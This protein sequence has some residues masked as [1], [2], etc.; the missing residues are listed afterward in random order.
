MEKITYVEEPARSIPVMANVDVVVVGGGPAGLSAAVTSARLGMDTLLVERY[1]CFGGNITVCAVECP[2]W[3]RMPKTVESRTVLSELESRAVERGYSQPCMHNPPGVGMS[4]DADLFKVVCDEIVAENKVEPLLHCM[5]VYPVLE[6][7]VIRGIFTESKSGRQ[8]ILAKRVIDCTGDGD[9]AARAG[10]PYEKGDPFDGRMMGCTLVF[11]MSG[12]D[13]KM[14]LDYISNFS[15]TTADPVDPNTLVGLWMPFDEAI[16]AGEMPGVK[17]FDLKYNQLTSAGEATALNGVSWWDG[18]FDCTNVKD[19]TYAEMFLRKR[20]LKIVDVLKKHQAGFEHA[21]LRN[22]AM[23][24]GVRESRRFKG[25]YTLS[26]FDV[27][28]QARFE[29]SIG[30]FPVHADGFGTIIVP[31]TDAYFEVPYRMIVPQGI[32]NLLVAGRCVSG[33]RS[34]LATTRE[35]NFC[36]ITGQGAAAAAAVSIQDKVFPRNVN[37]EK[38]QKK[39]SSLDIRVH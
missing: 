33:T 38:V 18:T 35:M 2:S 15:N 23:Q 37:I 5:G 1:G 29:D 6:G 11:G 4:H 31:D 20:V 13:V 25:E 3:Y 14:F 12:V 28:H 7:N 36:S 8:A 24:A 32:E 19:L 39:L 16:K 9:I 10:A 34:V 26:S 17:R 30:L 22:F 27:V 21:K